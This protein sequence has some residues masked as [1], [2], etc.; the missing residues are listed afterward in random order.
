[1]PYNPS[2]AGVFNV[3]HSVRQV[4]ASSCSALFTAVSIINVPHFTLVRE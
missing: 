3:V 4:R 2:R 1:M